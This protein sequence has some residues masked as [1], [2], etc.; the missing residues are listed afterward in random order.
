MDGGRV[1][2]GSGWVWEVTVFDRDYT[3]VSGVAVDEDTGSAKFF[4]GFD[5]R[6]G[7]KGLQGYKKEGFPIAERR[8]AF[9]P[10]NTAKYLTMTILSLKSTPCST[11]L[12]KSSFR[13]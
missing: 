1:A 7:K 6:G 3:V 8:L 5:L 9:K 10:R 4:C 12:S 11:N 13:P 2:S